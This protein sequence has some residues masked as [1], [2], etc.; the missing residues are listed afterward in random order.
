LKPGWPGN[1]AHRKTT[2][3]ATAAR[4]LAEEE[5]RRL[6]NGVGELGKGFGGRG[7]SVR[8]V[9]RERKESEGGASGIFNGASGR[10]GE[11]GCHE[12]GSVGMVAR[13]GVAQGTRHALKMALPSARA[14]RMGRGRAAR[15]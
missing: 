14:A 13:R 12:G 7:A 3:A 11:G 10:D 8:W 6:E 4:N 2:L 9:P 15:E 1:G 5:L